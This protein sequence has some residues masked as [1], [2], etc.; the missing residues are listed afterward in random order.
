MDVFQPFKVAKSKFFNNNNNNNNVLLITEQN[1][2]GTV[3]LFVDDIAA[4]KLLFMLTRLPTF[5][6]DATSD[7]PLGKSDHNLTALRLGCVT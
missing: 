5:A 1:D 6:N 7:I 2:D 3:P 4:I